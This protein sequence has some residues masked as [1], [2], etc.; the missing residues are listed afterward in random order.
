MKF[1]FTF[2]NRYVGF[3][4]G[5]SVDIDREREQLI[6][7]WQRVQDTCEQNYPVYGEYKDWFICSVVRKS[8]GASLLVPRFYGKGEVQ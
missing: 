3:S 5:F 1:L 6:A 8:D 2:Y 7:A 4:L